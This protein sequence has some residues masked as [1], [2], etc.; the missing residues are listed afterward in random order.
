MLSAFY[1]SALILAEQPQDFRWITAAFIVLLI[2]ALA[3]AGILVLK[4]HNSIR[5]LFSGA[6]RALRGFLTLIGIKKGTGDVSLDEAIKS[7]GYAYDPKQ[8]IFY[9][10]KDPWQRELG[11]C[12]LYDEAAAPLGMIIDCEPFYFQYGGKRWLIELWKGQYDMTTGC[13]IGVY[14]TDGPDLEIPGFFNGTFYECASDEDQLLMSYSLSKNGRALFAG[15]SRHW[16]LTGFKL[17]EY[18]EPSELI[19]DISITLKDAEM[20]DAFLEGL[21]KAGYSR[22]ELVVYLNTVYLRFGKPRTPQPLTRIPE[23]DWVIQKKN[24][25]LCDKYQEVTGPCRTFP[26][27]IKAI[28][29]KA[30]WMYEKVMNVGK[31]RQ[32]F[33]GYETI[34]EHLE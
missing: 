16:W 32:L 14:T 30:P 20:R 26:E 24:K 31:T 25:L 2:S 19:M 3:A 34:K 8:D 9:S 17:G 11:Y 1:T 28:Q 10:I 33:S 12:R 29:E 5:K 4:G 13:E 15:N 21:K 22:N 27:K 23:T 7:A 6:G 18:S